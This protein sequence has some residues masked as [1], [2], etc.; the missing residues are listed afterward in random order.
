MR[1]TTRC[2]AALVAGAA[3]LA[4]GSAD[5]AQAPSPQPRLLGL[6]YGKFRPAGAS[7]RHWALR[8]RA[9]DLDG[10]ITSVELSQL[11]PPGPI[12]HLDGGCLGS[13]GDGETATW[14]APGYLTSRRYRFRVK[15]TSASCNGTDVPAQERS[16]VRRLRVP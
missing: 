1:P 8:V 16:F 9:R 12:M 14:Y 6:R 2:S 15:L 3:V 10:S 7:H 13:P 4:F 5:A 11:D